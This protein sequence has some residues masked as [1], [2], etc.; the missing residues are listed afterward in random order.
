MVVWSYIAAYKFTEARLWITLPVFTLLAAA[1]VYT[2]VL[3][4][5]RRKAHKGATILGLGFLF[6]G[7]HLLAF[8][9]AESFTPLVTL[10]YLVSAALAVMISVGMIVEQESVISQQQYRDLF[11]SASDAIFLLDPATLT[12]LEVNCAAQTLTARAE[13]ELVGRKFLEL[14]PSIGH[15]FDGQPAA[16]AFIEVLNRPCREFQAERADGET[17]FCEGRANLAACPK[18]TVLQVNVRDI[19]ARM[20]AEEAL[21]ESV[22]SLSS[23]VA[24]LRHTQQ[25]VIQQQRLQALEQMASGVAHDFNNALAKVLGFAELLSVQPDNLRDPD[26]VKKYLQMISAAALDAVKIVNRLREFY[27]HRANTDTYASVNLEEII[28]QAITLTQPRWKDQVLARGVTIQFN[29]QLQPVPVVRGNAVELREALVNLIFNAVD[30]MVDGGT[31][32]MA[33]RIEQSTILLEVTDTGIGMTEEVRQQCLEPFFSTK[34]KDGTGLGLAIV[35]GIIHRHGGT[36]EI[37]SAPGRGATITVS[38]PP[39]TSEKIVAAALPFAAIG[40]RTLLVE[41]DA[42]LREILTEYLAS[43]GHG[44][45]TANDGNDGLEK[46]RNGHFDLV[47]TDQ[48][49]PV[50]NGDQMAAAIKLLAPQVPIVMVTGFADTLDAESARAR[51]IQVI[52]PKPVTP[53]ALQQAIHQAQ[54]D[55][56]QQFPQSVLEIAS[57]N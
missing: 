32:T 10:G 47:V 19:T 26:K 39:Q 56:R 3:F 30:A 53:V 7:L 45:V 2:G 50:M 12:V 37:R 13:P 48:A 33:L 25:Q 17:V 28:E 44:V 23:T 20:R 6:W 43:D 5:R 16:A 36:I 22:T 31:I 14:F 40:C 38:L 1:G 52:L 15:Q 57:S 41:D 18:G 55:C 35:Y 9:L 4:L 8:P 11:D 46:F 24:E 27:R 49:M 34:G 21:Q 54:E 51:G 42:Q 29:L